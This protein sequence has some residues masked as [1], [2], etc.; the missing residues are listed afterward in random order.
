MNGLYRHRLETVVTDKI[1][2]G[3]QF[4]GVSSFY[5]YL[6]VCVVLFLQVFVVKM[7]N[8]ALKFS[9]QNEVRA[10]SYIVAFNI[11]AL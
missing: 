1:F 3:T 9:V 4:A 5:D 2:G 11:A 10:Y 6:R 8:F 7:K